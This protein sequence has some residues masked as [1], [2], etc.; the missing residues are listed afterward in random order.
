MEDWNPQ[1]TYTCPSTINPD[2]VMPVENNFPNSLLQHHAVFETQSFTINYQY[3]R[4]KQV[5]YFIFI[6]LYTFYI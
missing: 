3:Y 1:N 5:Y 4:E 6:L 2:D